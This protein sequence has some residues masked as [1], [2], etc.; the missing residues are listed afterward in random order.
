MNQIGGL[1]VIKEC[2]NFLV[3]DKSYFSDVKKVH[4]MFRYLSKQKIHEILKSYNEPKNINQIISKDIIH[5]DY[6]TE[7]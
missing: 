6:W 1:V 3:L 2:A 7:S 4:S 5:S